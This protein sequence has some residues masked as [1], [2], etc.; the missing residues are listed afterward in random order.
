MSQLVGDGTRRQPGAVQEG[1]CGLAEDVTGD[2]GKPAPRKAVSEVGLGVGR[3]PQTPF[4]AGKT[5][6]SMPDAL[7]RDARARSIW[8]HHEGRANILIPAV[9]LVVGIRTS[10]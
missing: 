3:V 1:G 7:R 6:S 9:V 5:G 10:P 8:I 4:S 2:P